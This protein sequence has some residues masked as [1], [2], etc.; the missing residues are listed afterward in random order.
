MF[1]LFMSVM[2]TVNAQV[3]IMTRHRKSADPMRNESAMTYWESRHV[4]VTETDDGK[5]YLSVFNPL[6]VSKQV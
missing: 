3:E 1:L 4:A 2:L 6:V 5:Y